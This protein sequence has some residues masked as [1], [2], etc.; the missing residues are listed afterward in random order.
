[1][2]F[3]VFNKQLSFSNI[4][5]IEQEDNGIVIKI[6]KK[7]VLIDCQHKSEANNEETTIA[8]KSSWNDE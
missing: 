6:S 8:D 3:A 2:I 1:M 7:Y 5:K 4:E